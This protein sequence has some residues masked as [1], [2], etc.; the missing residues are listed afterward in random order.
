[1]FIPVEFADRSRQAGQ[2]KHAAKAP[3]GFES[4]LN[5]L[6]TCV[7][8]AKMPVV[9]SWPSA[10]FIRVGPARYDALKN[11]EYIPGWFRADVLDGAASLQHRGARGTR[12]AADLASDARR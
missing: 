9:A 3:M 6:Q 2:S 4:W 5:A 1:M 8:L 11:N 7:F 10:I 12:T